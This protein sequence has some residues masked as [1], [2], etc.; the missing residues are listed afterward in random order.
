MAR[1]EA[2]VVLIPELREEKHCEE[3]VLP[4]PFLQ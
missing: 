1:V 3:E 4:W 2:A